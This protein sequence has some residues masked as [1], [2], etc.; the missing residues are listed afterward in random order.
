MRTCNWAD[1]KTTFRRFKKKVYSLLVLVFFHIDIIEVL[2]QAP[3]T[4]LRIPFNVISVDELIE[5]FF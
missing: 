4:E 5:D 2:L 3:Q 1:H